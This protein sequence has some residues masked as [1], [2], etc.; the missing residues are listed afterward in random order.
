MLL[1]I[2]ISKRNRSNSNRRTSTIGP[3]IP[4]HRASPSHR[5]RGKTF[6][7][8]LLK[9]G[10]LVQGRNNTRY[11]GRT[12]LRM[13]FGTNVEEIEVMGGNLANEV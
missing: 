4:D 10:G 1:R 7:S 6:K 13:V 3:R 8:L 5:K 12:K 11:F 2:T 9:S